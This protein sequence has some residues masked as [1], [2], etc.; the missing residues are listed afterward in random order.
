MRNISF[1]FIVFS[2]VSCN[3]SGNLEKIDKSEEEFV[4]DMYEPSEMTLLMRSMY[5]I[6]EELKKKI[7][8]GNTP[9]KFPKEFLNIFMASLTDNKPQNEI[10]KA[11]SKVFIDKERE[12]FNEANELP[13]KQRYNS[14]I[15]TCISCHSTECVG[16][17]TR[18][19]KLLIN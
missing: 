13:L 15:N 9:D 18:I 2:F 3:N 17:I 4:F 8:A 6:N 11:Y 12:I 19:E 14:T 7:L 5:E 1:L 10:F 16:P